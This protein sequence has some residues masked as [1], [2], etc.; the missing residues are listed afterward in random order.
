MAQ[1]KKGK[2][3]KSSSRAKPKVTQKPQVT[4]A[5][6]KKAKPRAK[7]SNPGS[8]SGSLNGKSSRAKPKAARGAARSSSDGAAAAATQ[9]ASKARIPLLAGSAALVGAVGGV[10]LGATRSG[11]K[12]LGLT[13]PHPPRV[14]I[15]SSDLA[16]AAKEVGRFG[17]QVGELTT[18]LKQ[19][20]EGL[21]KG[22]NSPLEII[23]KGLTARR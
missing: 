16:A 21:G 7:R 1:A 3:A 14:R 10:M 23:L 20:R 11:S 9:A 15:R 19:A 8:R 6:A 5:R 2:Q 18:E 12:V 4:A 22:Q 13:L 17:E